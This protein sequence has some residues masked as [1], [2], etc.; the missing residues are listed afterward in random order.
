MWSCGV[1]LF[2]LLTGIP[3]FNGENDV[4]IIRK[5]EEGK[6]DYSTEEFQHVSKEA[7]SLLKKLLNYDPK[8]RINASTALDDPWI[9]K[10]RNKSTNVNKG[11]AI[12]V[13]EKLQNFKVFIHFTRQKIPL[14]KHLWRI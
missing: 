5:V 7:T 1:I 13:L 4:E 9:K 8:Q 10:Y 6:V 3:P 14:Q 12:K 2:I 11:K